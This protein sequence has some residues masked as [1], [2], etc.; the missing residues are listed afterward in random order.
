MAI[1]VDQPKMSACHR[2]VSSASLIAG[3]AGQAPAG[4]STASVEPVQPYRLRTVT[5]RLCGRRANVSMSLSTTLRTSSCS[6]EHSSMCAFVG[7]ITLPPS[8]LQRFERLT[9]RENPGDHLVS[10]HADRRHLLLQCGTGSSRLTHSIIA[11]SGCRDVIVHCD[12]VGDR[13]SCTATI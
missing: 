10:C 6:R 8:R 5:T 9:P 13:K 12:T 7:S 11:C 2:L 1:Y 3:V 4:T